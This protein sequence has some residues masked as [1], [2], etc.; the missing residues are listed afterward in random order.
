M[1]KQFFLTIILFDMKKGKLKKI[2]GKM[3]KKVNLRVLGMNHYV[4]KGGTL[5]M[6]GPFKLFHINYNGSS[7]WSPFHPLNITHLFKCL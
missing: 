4:F 3:K 5:I 2:V 1:F 7:T 6:L